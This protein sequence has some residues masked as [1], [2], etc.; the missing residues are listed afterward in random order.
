M[1]GR[2][3][4]FNMTVTAFSLADGDIIK[5]ADA[6]YETYRNRLPVCGTCFGEICLARGMQKTAYWR[7]FPGVGVDCPDKSDIKTVVYQVSN[8]INRKQ[9]LA[10]FKQRFLEILDIAIQPR[11][12]WGMGTQY[13]SFNNPEILDFAN[14]VNLKC[15]DGKA[16]FNST[17]L[18]IC[19]TH[20]KRT[21]IIAALVDI[22][23]KHL[24]NEKF[25]ELDID[26]EY[27][28]QIGQIA[29]QYFDIQMSTSQ[30]AAAYIFTPGKEDILQK[31]MAYCW[32]LYSSAF[33]ESHIIAVPIHLILI[34]TNI[35]ATI[36]WYHIMSAFIDKRVPNIVPP[37]TTCEL[38]S[39]GIQILINQFRQPMPKPK[40]KGFKPG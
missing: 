38:S 21:D 14:V 5:P 15:C 23:V 37:K 19:N 26:Y 34:A 1:N 36:P 7:H 33:D 30:L 8:R 25:V 40:P 35:I 31:L 16:T 4:T 20:R 27:K 13:Y 9:S 12:D 6:N 10:L 3:Q 18:D 32:L 17:M 11:F 28:K 39:N 22:N 2:I 24:Y 29:T